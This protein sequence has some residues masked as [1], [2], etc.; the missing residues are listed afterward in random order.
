ME[1]EN[2]RIKLLQPDDAQ[3]L[4]TLID[5]NRDRLLKY[6]PITTS[7]VTNLETASSYIEDM[8][9]RASNK[10]FYSYLIEE[11]STETIVG[12]YIL[13]NF[14]WRVPKCELAYFIGKNHEGKGIASK[15][16][17]GVVDFCFTD[18]KLNKIWIETGEDNM[19]SKT[20]KW[21]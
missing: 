21:K 13:K 10:E 11:K 20:S 19:G 16:T 15:I 5:S 1:I 4:I 3:K 14:N 2:Y 6:F 17:K 18:L 7:S 12:M 8:V 9:K